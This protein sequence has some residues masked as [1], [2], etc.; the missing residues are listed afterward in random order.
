MRREK[1]PVETK[2]HHLVLRHFFHGRAD[3]SVVATGSGCRR[4]V[5]KHPREGG[6][7]EGFP[8]AHQASA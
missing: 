4:A 2:K 5:K 3:L 7:L 6:L 1:D 8:V